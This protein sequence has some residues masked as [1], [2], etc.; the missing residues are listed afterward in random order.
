MRL[1]ILLFLLFNPGGNVAL[2]AS[3]NLVNVESYEKYWSFV[4]PKKNSPPETVDSN[5]VRGNIDRFILDKL[6]AKIKAA[7]WIFGKK[8]SLLYISILVITKSIF[9]LI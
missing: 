4:N 5:W 3:E 7:P 8:V 1:L 2:D 9:Q 6:E